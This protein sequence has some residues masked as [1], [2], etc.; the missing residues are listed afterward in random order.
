MPYDRPTPPA[1]LATIALILGGIGIGITEFVTMGLLP[2]I[3]QGLH[4]SIPQAGHAISAYAVGVVVGAPVLAAW[5][6]PRPRKGLLI[7][8]ALAIVVGNALSA[9]APTYETLLVARVMA[10]LPHG[11]YFGVASLVAIDLAPPGQSGRAVGR[12]MLG[13]PIA[14][15]AGVPLVTWMGQAIG[16]RSGYWTV[17]VVA[18]AATALIALAVPR[19]NA[20][21]GASVRNELRAF[22]S[23]QV[24]L[25]FI[26]GSI[27]FGGIFAMYSYVAPLITEV[28]GAPERLVPLALFA[29]GLGGL[30]GNTAGGRMSDWSVLR[31]I[32]IS[33]LAMAL[34]LV[35]LALTARWFVA[36]LALI[37]LA[38]IT[39][40]C[41][42]VAVMLR[43]IGVARSAQ[44][45]GAASSHASLNIA[46]ALGAWLGGVVIARGHGYA[47]PSLVGAVLALGGLAVFGLSI[48]KH[49]RDLRAGQAAPVLDGQADPEPY[50]GG[51][52]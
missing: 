7:G 12:V 17:A 9:L 37:F 48:V 21:D 30:I 26:A 18:L 5:G 20:P 52:A 40:G 46:N 28:S 10:G 42:A 33:S 11:A 29:F 1:L 49:R 47:A 44:T 25:T 31:A 2:Q 34:A 3:A 27:G 22:G 51:V 41:L 32:V 38:S 36:A 23:V 16:W 43:L 15:L 45:L 19:T 50:G 13:I 14:N 35:A 4:A 8:L 24:A 6:A 39:G